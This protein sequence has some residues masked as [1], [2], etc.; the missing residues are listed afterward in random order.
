[1]ILTIPGEFTTLNPFISE[2]R[3]NKYAGALLKK[4]ETLRVYYE[5]LVQKVKKIKLGRGK[6]YI[7]F[8]W[9]RSNKKTDPDNIAFARKFIMDGL[10]LAKVIPDD[11]WNIIGGFSDRFYVDKKNPRVDIILETN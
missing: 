4:E 2:N 10:V 5:M 9:Y 3:K 6:L 11:T 8:N 7:R 1:M